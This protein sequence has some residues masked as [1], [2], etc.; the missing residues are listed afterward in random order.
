MCMVINYLNLGPVRVGGKA[1][2]RRCIFRKDDV[3]KVE[4]M[5][6]IGGVVGSEEKRQAVRRG[7]AEA[8]AALAE[9]TVGGD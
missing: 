7:A 4:E 2:D 1:G 3:S 8:T 5:A 9:T 6:V